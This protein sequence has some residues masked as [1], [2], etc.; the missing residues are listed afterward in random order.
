MTLLDVRPSPIAGT[1]YEG[2]RGQLARAVDGYLDAASL[3]AL[4][5]EVVA[6]IAPPVV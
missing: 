3:P 1:W 6:V 5:G 4:D 2:D